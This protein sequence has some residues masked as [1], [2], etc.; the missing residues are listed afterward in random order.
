MKIFKKAAAV[1][2]SSALCLLTLAACYG[3]GK[4]A[5]SASRTQK[6]SG[7]LNL[8]IWTEYIPQSVIDDFTKQ[9]GI[10]VN[11]STYSTN[12]D[13]LAKVKASNSGIYDIVVPSDYMVKMMA[14]Q[15]LLQ[16]LDKSKLTN[17]S[18]ID[19]AYMDKDFDKGNNYS[20]PYLGGVAALCINKSEV[21][22]KITSFKQVLDPKYSDSVVALDDFRAVIGMTSKSLGYSLST[23]DDGQLAKVKEQLAKLKPNIKALDSD[24][25]KTSMINGETSIGFMWNGEIALCMQESDDFDVVFP[26]EGCYIFLDNMCVLKGAENYGSAMKF[27]NYILEAKTEKAI[28]SEFP[29]LS[30]NKA[31]IALMPE[32]YRNNKASNVPKGVVEKSEYVKD[33]GSAVS[34]YDDMWTDFTK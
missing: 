25:P 16:K 22:E 2:V 21:K 15:G 13:M 18:N 32:S 17:L 6:S 29:Y 12:E 23:T 5:Q 3:A 1:A 26:S 31:A 7:E 34:K 4:S 33:I 20:V 10:E 9:T 28:L 8:F 11:V 24:S 27:I 30:P 19:T 14:D